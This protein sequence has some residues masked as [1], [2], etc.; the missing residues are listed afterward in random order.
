MKE[1]KV[2]EKVWILC[3]VEK[4]DTTL[5]TNKDQD[6]NVIEEIKTKYSL[7]P[8]ALVGDYGRDY[9]S[10]HIDNKNLDRL[11]DKECIELA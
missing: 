5:E 1:L 11:V 3:T 10:L 9:C 7:M 8:S 6:C 2:G 4:K